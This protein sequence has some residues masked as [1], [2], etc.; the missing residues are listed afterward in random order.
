MMIR[1]LRLA[2]LLAPL[3]ALAFAPPVPE[4][5][6]KA[7]L[8]TDYQSG[9]QLAARDADQRIEPASLTKLM[10]AYLSFKAV[11]EG[12]LKLDQKFTVSL[13]G[14]KVGGSTMFL[15]PDHPASVDDLIKGMIVVSGNDACVTLAEAIAGSEEVFAQMMTAEAKRLGMN[16]SNFKN[17]AGM[18]DPDHYTTVGDLGKLAVA[19]I[20]DFPEFYPI[21]AMKS[22][23]YHNGR[24]SHT[25]P[26]RNLLLYR[27][28]FV[29][30]L[31]TGHTQSAGY[32]LIAS[33]RRDGRRLISVVVGTSGEEV[34]ATES[35]KLLNWGVQF[36][37]T[38][39]VL[40][41]KQPLATPQVWKGQTDTVAIGAFEDRF[42]TVDRGD[43]AKLQQQVFV[44][45]KLIAPLKA[46]QPLGRVVYS[47]E[48]KPVVEYPLVA[49]QNVEEAG[50]FK[51][52]WHTIKLWFV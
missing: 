18:P 52:L 44:N 41:A 45:P 20:H 40:T 13:Q 39:K 31:K 30:G 50:F 6:G 37:E 35:A 46:G 12:R 26:N 5:A 43:A 10:T 51:R 3:S 9:R 1:A 32:N 29:D 24:K 2:L 28:A 23:T 25:Q 42:V 15:E 8:L 22:F 34:R 36:F 17:S 14:Y 16:G 4:I 21:Y 33:T 19:I 47:L 38:P 27:D 48:G 7:Y 11:K 49:L